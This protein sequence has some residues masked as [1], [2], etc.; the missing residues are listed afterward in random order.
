MKPFQKQIGR[1][2][3]IMDD[4]DLMLYVIIWVDKDGGRMIM[5][6]FAM[7]RRTVRSLIPALAGYKPRTLWSKVGSTNHLAT[8]TIPGNIALSDEMENKNIGYLDT[9]IIPCL[10]YCKS[11]ADLEIEVKVAQN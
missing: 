11:S 6:L 2:T 8:R 3:G 1:H 5:K 10:Q 7:K 4:D 9:K